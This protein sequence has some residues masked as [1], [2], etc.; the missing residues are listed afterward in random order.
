MNQDDDKN[1]QIRRGIKVKIVFLIKGKL[2]LSVYI[3]NKK[4]QHVNRESEKI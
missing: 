3:Y 4:Y 2:F 1:E